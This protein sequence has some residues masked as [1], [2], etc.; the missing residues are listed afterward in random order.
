M[1]VK[2]YTISTLVVCTFFYNEVIGQANTSLS[3][4]VSPTAVNQD[5]LPDTT[6][7]LNLGSARRN[8]MRIYIGTDLYL[9]NI[10]TMHAP[11]PLGSN[12][13][14]GQYSGNAAV[15]GKSNTALGTYSLSLVSSGGQ[16]TATGYRVLRNTT[17]GNHNTGSG[18]NTLY[19]NTSGSNNAAY[20]SRA[21][22]TNT[23]G[24]Y[25]VVLGYEAMYANTTG[26][27]NVAIGTS[28]LSS[29]TTTN[30]LVAV[31]DNALHSVNGGGGNNVATGSEAMYST[32]TGS[33]N[34]SS[35]NESMSD[36]TTGSFNTAMGYSAMSYN[37]TSDYN[38]S[39]G[40]SSMYFNSGEDNV[41]LGAWA[42]YYTSQHSVFLGWNARGA[43]LADV[44][45]STAIGYN[46]VVS[47]DNQVRIGNASVLSI[48]GPVAW[49][50]VSDSRFKKEINENVPGL[51]FIKLLRPV[52][53]KFD[54]AAFNSRIENISKRPSQLN[55]H[56]VNPA[57]KTSDDS[58]SKVT[59]TGFIAQEVEAAAKK[60][61]YDFSGIDEPKNEKDYYGLRYSDFVVP[62]VKAVQE[63]SHQNDSLREETEK[64]RLQN[65]LFEDRLKKIESTL[66]INS[67]SNLTLSG[68]SL[69]QNIPNPFHRNTTVNYSLP[70]GTKNAQIAIYDVVGK[71]LKKYNITPSINGTLE[72]DATMLPSGTYQ[73]SL[74]ANGKMIDTKKML[75]IK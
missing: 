8:W 15:T 4:L 50:V 65:S 1:T 74:I 33:Y 73:Y 31:G 59:Y 17:T 42:G 43:D 51:T 64:L 6:N 56:E 11:G 25:N 69:T 23:T 37:T 19:N 18:Y 14:I 16:N 32:T 35:G 34:T 5:L 62:L 21:L 71:L 41:A 44:T 12:F 20:G 28:A 39:I 53:Y 30:N 9:E 45:N 3:N 54:V 29:N 63:L 7:T 55:S 40:Y 47:A 24:N 2:N 46:T 61:N 60:M 13:F 22:Y 70:G 72:I 52:T 49:S 66:N 58:K 75:L 68:A 48:G 27:H 57:G 67:S 10:R 36:N 38:T 26:D